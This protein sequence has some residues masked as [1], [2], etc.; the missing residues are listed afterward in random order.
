MERRHRS[1]VSINAALKT[2]S[3]RRLDAASAATS[4]EDGDD[5]APMMSFGV[6]L[7]RFRRGAD[8]RTRRTR[9]IYAA[10]RAGP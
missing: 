8:T 7:P 1:L 6:A 10:V 3:Q 2:S 9:V 4:A 5:A